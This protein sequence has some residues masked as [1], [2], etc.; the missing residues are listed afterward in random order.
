MNVL[1]G[2]RCMLFLV[3]VMI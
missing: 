1:S 3:E 2:R